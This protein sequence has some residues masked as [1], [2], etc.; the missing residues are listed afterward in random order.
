M[1]DKDSNGWTPLDH[2]WFKSVRVLKF[3]K[4]FLPPT[5]MDNTPVVDVLKARM[6]LGDYLGWCQSAQSPP[7]RRAPSPPTP[8]LQMRADSNS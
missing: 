7:M 5:P 2:A 3:C 8:P 1:W 6:G 4:N